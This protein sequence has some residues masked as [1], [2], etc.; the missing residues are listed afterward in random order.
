MK[1]PQLVVFDCDGVLVDSEWIAN[2]VFAEELS[3]V[4][5]P[6]TVE[7]T[8]DRFVGR[9]MKSCYE[10]IEAQLGRPLPS[11]F[12]ERLD[13]ATYAAFDRDLKAVSGIELVLDRLDALR[14]PYCVASS[15]SLAKM[16]RTLGKTGLLDRFGVGTARRIYSSSQVARGKPFPDLFEF[17]AR[18]CMVAPEHCLVIED[19]VPGV[20]AAQ[21]AGMSVAGHAAM[22][23]PGSRER[24]A[25]AGA[26]VFSNMAE[27]VRWMQDWQ[28]QK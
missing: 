7:Q 15:G 3:K 12:S 24:L 20:Q 22:A 21:A 11:G 16:N 6:I 5:L 9:S 17:A 19:S 25:K 2:R 14:L 27:L 18:N 28:Q 13:G 8:M 4:G 23:Y 26:T 10:E 1:R